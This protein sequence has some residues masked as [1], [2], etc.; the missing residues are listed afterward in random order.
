MAPQLGLVLLLTKVSAGNLITEDWSYGEVS[1][2]TNPAP[3]GYAQYP[4]SFEGLVDPPPGLVHVTG[5]GGGSDTA[6]TTFMLRSP[7]FSWC[8]QVI[9]HSGAG[10]GGSEV[11]S[12]ITGLPSLSSSG[13]GF[14]GIALLDDSAQTYVLSARRPISANTSPGG[15]CNPEQASQTVVLDLKASEMSPGIYA[16]DVIDAKHG[17]WGWMHVY[18]VTGVNCTSLSPPE[19]PPAPPM[20]PPDPPAP[21]AIAA[22][23]DDPIFVG[24]DGLACAPLL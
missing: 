3:G 14:M 22:V 12:T 23:G 13:G 2:W 1:L 18:N 11:P 7:L 21:P 16:V 20:P 8:D 6:H 4:Y 9:M 19:A 5:G 24:A 15:C 17:S 10:G